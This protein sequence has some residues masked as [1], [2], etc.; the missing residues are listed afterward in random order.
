MK[1]KIALDNEDSHDG[2]PAIADT[3][4]DDTVDTQSTIS[5]RS[6]TSSTP[7][8]SSSRAKQP[9]LTKKF[10]DEDPL[11]SSLEE[12]SDQ[13]LS[14]QKQL[15]SHLRPSGDKERDTF[16]DWMRSAVHS[17][18]HTVWRRCQRELSDVMYRVIAEND[19]LQARKQ[20]QNQYMAAEVSPNQSSVNVRQT[21]PSFAHGPS[22]AW[23]PAPQFWPSSVQNPTSVW[24]SMDSSWVHQQY[25][26]THAHAQKSA[27]V[28]A[29]NQ[30]KSSSSAAPLSTLTNI[31]R[32]I[33]ESEEENNQYSSLKNDCENSD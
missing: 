10:S 24:G 11:I 25:P 12:R 4:D 1:E 5:E 27:P 33:R 26:S 16:I 14:M 21:S 9:R 18:E 19:N 30:A 28:Q 20:N 13:V 2:F 32:D 15:L 22:A 31:L 8:C 23:Q 7:L 17:L 29:Q 6:Q 3:T